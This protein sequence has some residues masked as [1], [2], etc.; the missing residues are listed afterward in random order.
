[1]PPLLR[2]I[3]NSRFLPTSGDVL[4]IHTQQN[5]S[6]RGQQC[7]NELKDVFYNL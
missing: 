3:D 7:K 5:K 2:L 6:T 4:R 1:V